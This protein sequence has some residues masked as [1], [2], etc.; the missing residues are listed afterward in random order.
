MIQ[1]MN[2]RHAIA[3]LHFWQTSKLQQIL[4]NILL[5]CS[6]MIEWNGDHLLFRNAFALHKFGGIDCMKETLI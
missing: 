5:A 6:L 2:W 4:Q 3:C 1:S